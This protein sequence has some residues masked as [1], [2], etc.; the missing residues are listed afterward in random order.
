MNFITL[1][2]NK[3][4]LMKENYLSKSIGRVRYKIKIQ[5]NFKFVIAYSYRSGNLSKTYFN[6]NQEFCLRGVFIGFVRFSAS[7]LTSLANRFQLRTG[8]LNVRH[9]RWMLNSI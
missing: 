1:M 5:D 7:K 4:K 8:F 6:A 9:F 3:L 2:R